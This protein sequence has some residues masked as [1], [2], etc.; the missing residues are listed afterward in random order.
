MDYV[1]RYVNSCLCGGVSLRRISKYQAD[2]TYVTLPPLF[3]QPSPL[4]AS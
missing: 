2:H 1:V 3:I 4:L